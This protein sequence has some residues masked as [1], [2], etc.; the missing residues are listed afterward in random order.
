[1]QLSVH[2]VA[3][4]ERQGPAMAPPGVLLHLWVLLNR[5]IRTVPNGNDG[6]SHTYLRGFSC[7][8]NHLEDHFQTLV[9]AQGNYHYVFPQKIIVIKC[10]YKLFGSTGCANGSHG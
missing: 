3:G 8:S 9:N 6:N 4:S 1:M 5:D 10:S 2:T 7:F